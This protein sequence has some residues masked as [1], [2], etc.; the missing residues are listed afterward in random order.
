MYW[1]DRGEKRGDNVFH[2]KYISSILAVVI[3]FFIQKHNIHLLANV[4]IGSYT[5]IL[6]ARKQ[7]GGIPFSYRILQNNEQTVKIK[8]LKL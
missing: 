2:L 8:E 5:Y 3:R 6:G 7:Y 4:W 1:K